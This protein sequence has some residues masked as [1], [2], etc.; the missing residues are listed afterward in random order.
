MDDKLSL[1]A[2]AGSLRSGSYNKFA[3]KNLKLLAPSNV[4]IEI[5]DLNNIPFMNE[6]LEEN[7]L[8]EPV[9]QLKEK[10]A[11]ADG[12]IIASPEYNNFF[13]GV[14]KNAIEWLTRGNN[15]TLSDKPVAVITASNG[16]F[17]GTRAQLQLR[18][19]LSVVGAKFMGKQMV[20]IA[21]AGEKFDKEGMI[22]DKRDK[23]H[24]VDF[25]ESFMIYIQT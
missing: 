19:L 9:E 22:I 25:L 1:V 14:T 4:T 17:G 8:P 11:N 21:N 6:D 24:L 5:I 7:G 20:S 12:L 15:N 2:I 23:K 10:T 3:L 16:Y 13:S 18:T